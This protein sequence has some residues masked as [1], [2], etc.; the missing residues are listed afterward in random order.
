MKICIFKYNTYW[1]WRAIEGYRPRVVVIEYNATIPPT[2]SKA[3]KYDP[4]RVWN[5]TNYFGASLLALVN[6]G[7][8][9]GY[10]FIGHDSTEVNA[11]FVRD[12]LRD[13]FCDKLLKK[14]YYLPRLYE[15]E[16]QKDECRWHHL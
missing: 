16:K 3:V 12:D 4:N 10:Y 14:L 5:G 9:K 13:H 8:S 1:V 2:E 15:I 7:K 6:L 11:F